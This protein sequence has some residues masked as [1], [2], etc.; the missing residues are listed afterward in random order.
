M[1]RICPKCGDYYADA[2]LAFCLVDGTP[3]ISVAQTSER[4]NEGARVIQEK[5]NAHRRQ[6]RKLK[7]RR[8]VLSAVT[9]MIAT[10][11]VYVVVANTLIYLKP[12]QEEK[13][14]LDTP[15]TPP[16]EAV[17]P[18]APATPDALDEE[19]P[20][21]SANLVLAESDSL[22]PIA[23]GGELAYTISV[24]NKG[25]DTAQAVRV[26]DNLP[27]TVTFVKCSANKGGV[28]GGAGNKRTIFF[29]SLASGATATITLNTTASNSLTRAA[30]IN[31]AA[32]VT[33]TTFDP[34]S[35]N[36][37]DTETTIVQAATPACSAADKG[38]EIESILKIYSQ[39]WEKEIR[40]EQ[41]KISAGNSPAG[42]PNGGVPNANVRGGFVSAG[43]TISPPKIRL[44]EVCTEAFVSIKYVWKVNP[45]GD[46]ITPPTSV[47]IRKEKKFTCKKTGETWH[48]SQSD[49]R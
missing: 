9:I 32:F 6:K 5:E 41:P 16:T 13:V 23:P 39:Q 27:S 25:P 35:V 20:T 8:I 46:R 47:D 22:D 21:P 44:P 28:C 42:N 43:V 14:V 26:T 4:W 29:E 40:G 2:L 24:T 30:T 34:A 33:S 18:I 15:L 38:R 19:P 49:F 37:S 31:N 1:I 7:R 3:L 17:E 12:R 36:N 45:N 48:C 11:V 10:M